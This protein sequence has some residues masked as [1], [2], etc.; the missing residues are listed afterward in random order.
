MLTIGDHLAIV[1]EGEWS[2]WLVADFPLLPHLVSARGM[3]RVF[4]RQLHPAL[5]A[6]RIARQCRS[7]GAVLPLSTPATF[8]RDVA[9]STGRYHTLGIPE[10]TSALRQG[11]LTLPQFL[12][13]TQ[14][15]FDD[16]RK[17]LRYGLSHFQ[18]GLLFAYFSV[19]DQGSHILWDRHEPELLDFYRAV[20]GCI[21]EVMRQEPSAELIV[22]SDHGFTTFTRAVHLN[23]WLYNRGFLTLSKR[24]G[25]ETNIVEADWRSPRLTR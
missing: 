6:I 5:G 17:L 11:V 24:P 3:F 18:G 7:D 25:E 21:G 23:T 13:Q 10:D 19:V 1:A 16:E 9:E 12:S 15:V 22:M 8:S 4:A 20:D 2:D 14:A